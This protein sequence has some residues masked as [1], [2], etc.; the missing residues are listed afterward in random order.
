VKEAV[1][2]R[3]RTTS[4]C[5]RLPA[6]GYDP[7]TRAEIIKMLVW[8]SGMDDEAKNTQGHTGYEDQ[9]AINDEDKGYLIVGC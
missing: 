1:P 9:D 6:Q 7:I 2:R 8:I 3:F 5:R 4:R